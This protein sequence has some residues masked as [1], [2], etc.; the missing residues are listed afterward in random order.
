MMDQSKTEIEFQG[1]INRLAALPR[2]ELVEHWVALYHTPPPKGLGQRLLVQAI[3]YK[4]Q[5]TRYGGLKPAVG[6][7]LLKLGETQTNN[8]KGGAD[9]PSRLQPG[10]RLVREW[11]GHTHVVDV[12][13]KGFIWKGDRHRSLSA[14]ARTITGT[15]WSGPRFFGVTS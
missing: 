1:E 11:N 15:R 13:D 7:R 8:N 5:A 6:R 10:T 4:M 3:G 14:I 9:K 2:A 12:V